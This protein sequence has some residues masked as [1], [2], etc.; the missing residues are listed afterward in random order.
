MTAALAAHRGLSR[1]V[2]H[3]LEATVRTFRTDFYRRR[4]GH[5]MGASLL[6]SYSYLKAHLRFSYWEFHFDTTAFG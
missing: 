1:S 6:I 5:W 3:L 2:V 4:I